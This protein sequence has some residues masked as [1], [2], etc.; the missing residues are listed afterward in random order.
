[1]MNMKLI[2]AFLTL[3]LLAAGLQTGWA[4]ERVAFAGGWVQFATLEQARAELTRADEWT[5]TAG[6]FQRANALGLDKTPDR[7]S[8]RLGLAKVAQAWTPERIQRWRQALAIIAPRF[9]ALH[10]RL[11]NTVMLVSTDGSEEGNAAY[12]RGQAVFIPQRHSSR[13][14]DSEFLAHEL[15]HILS[16]SDP[17]LADRIYALIGFVPAEP[18]EWPAAW[19]AQR[20]SNPDAPHHR[21][22]MWIEARSQRIAVMP[23]LAVS[24]TNLKPGETFFSVLD[25]RLLAV[26]PGAKGQPTLPV[27]RDGEPL[28]WHA[29][30]VRPYLD[31]LGGNTGYILHPE[32]VAADNFALLVSDRTVPNPQLLE[33][34][35]KVLLERHP[36]PSTR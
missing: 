13:Q 19:A 23:V 29:Q 12:T 34:I 11:P 2:R 5:A 28:W 6:D 16:R 20:I 25:I 21:H 1:M 26:K 15:F 7:E 31:K 33:S 14:S 22:V 17:E 30:T 4:Q 8:F 3:L 36:S 35:R 10:V 18:L 24:R 27:L 9:E 32:E